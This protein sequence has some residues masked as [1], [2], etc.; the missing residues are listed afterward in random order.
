MKNRHDPAELL[1]YSGEHLMHEITMLWQTAAT[2][3]RY[4]EGTIEYVALLESFAT[5]LRNLIEFL[6]FPISREYVRARHFFEEPAVW[7][8]NTTPPYWEDLYQRACH[9]VNHLTTGRIDGDPDSKVWEA[10]K[11]LIQIDPILREF[12]SKASPKKLHE[13]VRELLEQPTDKVLVWIGHNVR[14]PNIAVPAPITV[15]ALSKVNAST[16][17]VIVRK[18]SPDWP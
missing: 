10:G 5:H 11:I 4:P 2:L 14:H 6:F 12:A 3:P 16:A 17:T 13:K 1:Q 18:I 15:S 7:P 8:H 9:E